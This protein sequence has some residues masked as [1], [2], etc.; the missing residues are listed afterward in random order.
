[1]T[2]QCCLSFVKVAANSRKIVE[3]GIAKK[4]GF[5]VFVGISS[6]LLTVSDLYTIYIYTCS[7]GFNGDLFSPML[8]VKYSAC[9][10]SEERSGRETESCYWS[11]TAK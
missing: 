3:F 5:V 8:T 10:S 7:V 2:N 1:M 4:F 6:P 9:F 11:L